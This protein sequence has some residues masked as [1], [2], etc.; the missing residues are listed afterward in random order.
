MN[1]STQELLKNTP[2]DLIPRGE[3][4]NS[5]FRLLPQEEF[6]LSSLRVINI[7]GSNGVG[8]TTFIESLRESDF[9]AKKKIVWISPKADPSIDTPQEFIAACSQEVC[10]PQ[11]PQMEESISER[12]DESQKGKVDPIRSDDSLLITRSTITENK[13]PYVNAAAAASVGR[14]NFVREDIEVSVGLGN[15]RSGNQAEAFLD[16]LPLQ[17]MGAD[18]VLLHLEDDDVLSGPVRDWFRD[19]LIP[20]ATK[21][22]YRRNLMVVEENREP[23]L[24]RPQEQ[25]W[26]E[27]DTLVADFELNPAG[28]ESV[29]DF[30]T[31]KGC[32]QEEAK[33]VFVKG[34]GYPEETLRATEELTTHAIS[35]QSI[36]TA[37]ERVAALPTDARERLAIYSL[38][39]SIFP[40]EIDAIFGEGQSIEMIKWLSKLPGSIA[41]EQTENGLRFDDSIRL[42]AINS[43]E[44][45]R[46]FRE[47]EQ[48][49]LPYARLVRNVPSHA[50]RSSLYL[51]SGLEW[52]DGDKHK[53]L[54]GQNAEDITNLLNEKKC[55]FAERKR[56]T[57]ISGVLRRDLETTAGNI[58]HG[59][60][61]DIDQRAAKIWETREAY[62]Q[63]KLEV[64]GKS[65]ALVQERLH[66]IQTKY[67]QVSVLI[68]RFQKN[69][70]PIPNEP[71]PKLVRGKN[72]LYLTLLTLIA[73]GTAATGL[74]L[75]M[76]A[77]VLAFVASGAAAV[78]S[79]ALVPGWR[80]QAAAKRSHKRSQIKDSP[81]YLKRENNEL[82]R[83]M[84][85]NQT[86]Y[87]DLQR[88]ISMAKEELE[89]HYV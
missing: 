28:I 26:G 70:T 19:Y 30:A 72:S 69:G 16:A 78:S 60:S 46:R 88:E 9:M 13:K 23:Y 15:N 62:L 12:L 39:E 47:A 29:I 56:F 14:T 74:S 83:R 43:I 1:D 35:R 40:D 34:L 89:Y 17:S 75:E 65:L 59:G 64:L 87:D 4:A 44:E 53:T 54:F 52:I 11:N 18:L 10:F 24:L 6:T 57:R 55:Y 81:E 20:S 63:D 37:K 8:K 66:V 31:S 48:R 7:W 82:I 84:Q 50:D 45:S 77:S 21:G 25:A 80:L 86:A 76:P 33:F 41:P 2:E 36:A 85:E 71:E 3:A 58:G 38:P 68:K 49:W 5:F 67:T 79:L 51:L 32:S 73:T 22:P 61:K 42:A 27:W